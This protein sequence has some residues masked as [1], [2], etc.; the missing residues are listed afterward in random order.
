M[1]DEIKKIYRSTPE[2]DLVAELCFYG[3]MDMDQLDFMVTVIR[4]RK[5][6]KTYLT[7]AGNIR[8]VHLTPE[9]LDG[10]LKDARNADIPV[11]EGSFRPPV[12]VFCPALSGMKEDEI[13]DVAP[14]AAKTREYLQTLPAQTGQ[15]AAAFRIYF[16]GCEQDLSD[17]EDCD[18]I[19]LAVEKDL[20]RILIRD[21]QGILFPLTPKTTAARFLSYVKAALSLRQTERTAEAY[22]AAFWSAM[23]ALSDDDRA[24]VP[25]EEPV[26]Q[27]T[28][29]GDFT[30]GPQVYKQ[31]QPD[32]YAAVSHPYAGVVPVSYW[33]KLQTILTGNEYTDVEIRMDRKR[34]L[35]I[36]NLLADE[37]HLP[38]TALPETAYTSTERSGV[39][40]RC[41]VCPA[42]TADPQLFVSTMLKGLRQLRLTEKVLPS[43][44]LSGCPCCC[45]DVPREDL[46]FIM[47]KESPEDLPE[48]QYCQV[49][50]HAD[51]DRDLGYILYKNA[52]P[53][54]MALGSLVQASGMIFPQW[55]PQNMELLPRL[56]ALY[57]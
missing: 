20:F 49:I 36:C 28:G 34:T 53:F 13:F 9:A 39:S 24:D 30:C 27:K 29:K 19:F 50:L 47:Q 23:N 25:V 10:V 43:F 26:I 51:H 37:V 6:A 45:P 8:L 54:L 41:G 56:T 48:G 15:D 44:T 17:A 33:K 11:T 4:E 1:T 12:Q 31:K 42:G 57:R 52:F 22:P 55:Y 21:T 3:K 35:Y 2:N 7:E 5:L 16:A 46:I 40:D 32:L 14:Y 18:M 38:L